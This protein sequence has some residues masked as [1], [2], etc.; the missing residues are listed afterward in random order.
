MASDTGNSLHLLSIDLGSAPS[1]LR[2]VLELGPGDVEHW[3]KRAKAAGAP[4]AI[5]C[6]PETVDLYSTE[7]GR[8]AAF[9]PLLESLWSLGQNVEGFERIRTREAYGHAVVRHMLRQAAGL[10]STEHGLSY[11]GCIAQARTQAADYG[12]LSDALGQLFDLACSTADR[13]EAET[14]LSAPYS[15]RASRQI[16]ALTA[17]RIMEEELTAF[18]VA[19]ANDDAA[20]ASVPAPRSSVAAPAARASVLPRYTADEPG[21]SVRIRIS[22]FS[23]A[24]VSTRKSAS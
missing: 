10:E 23:L 22:P 3:L 18:R 13:S 16:E 7:A 12:T 8:R 6:G 17:E 11:A 2:A 20:R 5:V 14:Q 1:S 4:L 15:T 9:K 19:A 24:P 21:S